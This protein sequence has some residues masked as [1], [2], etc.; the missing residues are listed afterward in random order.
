MNSLDSLPGFNR[1]NFLRVHD[2]GEQVT[3]IRFNPAKSISISGDPEYSKSVPWS[4]FGYYLA[5]RPIFTLDP[6]FHGGAYYVQEASS[7]FL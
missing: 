1:E 2:S 5:E 3:S 6:F 7:M 4:S